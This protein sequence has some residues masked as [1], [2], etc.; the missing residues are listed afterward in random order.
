MWNVDDN[1][2]GL[3]P[4]RLDE[5]FV[6]SKHRGAVTAWAI[7]VMSRLPSVW[8]EEER[9]GRERL[10]ARERERWKVNNWPF[11]WKSI[12]RVP[13]SPYRQPLPSCPGPAI[14]SSLCSMQTRRIDCAHMLNNV[15]T[16]SKAHTKHDYLRV[17]IFDSVWQ[18]CWVLRR[19][20]RGFMQQCRR[21]LRVR[22]LESL[23]TFHEYG[24]EVCVCVWVSV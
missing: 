7:Y 6:Y 18:F 22:Y 12:L 2:K 10:S 4:L 21:L 5:I 14:L 16:H 13:S 8:E 20:W 11:M 19:S 17:C 3:I 9:G 23:L 24:Q 15:Q 1:N